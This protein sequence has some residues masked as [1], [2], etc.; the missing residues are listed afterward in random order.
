MVDTCQQLSPVVITKI[1]Q[2]LSD[3]VRDRWFVLMWVK[4]K[5]YPNPRWTVY[6]KRPQEYV[7]QF[8]FNIFWHS[9]EKITSYIRILLYNLY[10]FLKNFFY[11]FL[12]ISTMLFNYTQMKMTHLFQ[13]Q[14]NTS[15]LLEGS[16]ILGVLADT[17]W[18]RPQWSPQE[19]LMSLLCSCTRKMQ[20]CQ[21]HLWLAVIWYQNKCTL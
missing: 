12:Y 10:Y 13:P 3:F 11:S 5:K 18:I 15:S 2:K 6:H 1:Y 7:G 4:S 19:G 20:Y 17:W 8:S 9:L 21:S 16:N 14:P